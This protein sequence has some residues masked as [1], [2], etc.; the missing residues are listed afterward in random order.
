MDKA[1]LAAIRD[2]A[3]RSLGDSWSALIGYQVRALGFM[4]IDRMRQFA[5][6]KGDNGKAIR[7]VLTAYDVVVA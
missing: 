7:A 6:A 2:E 1:T 4:G 3:V 5:G